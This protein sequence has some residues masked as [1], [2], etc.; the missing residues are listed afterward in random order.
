[1]TAQMETTWDR[2]EPSQVC[3]ASK[4]FREPKK[5]L[6]QNVTKQLHNKIK[7]PAG[8]T[9][10]RKSKCSRINNR[11]STKRHPFVQRQ[12]PPKQTTEAPLTFAKTLS[13]PKH[14]GGNILWTE[15]TNVD[16]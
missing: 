2:V 8:L 12:K 11:K 15:E 10:L 1:M 5:R 6:I 4:L 16:L 13:D 3:V 7:C 14:F 9:C